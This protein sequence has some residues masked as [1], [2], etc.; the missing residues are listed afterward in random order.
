MK[1]KVDISM[2]AAAAGASLW[3]GLISSEYP[4]LG[5]AAAILLLLPCIA[6]LWARTPWAVVPLSWATAALVGAVLGTRAEAQE[7]RTATANPP[8]PSALASAAE[9][10]PRERVPA[11]PPVRLPTQAERA[12]AA[13]AILADRREDPSARYCN[14]RRLL[15]QVPPV[16]LRAREQRALARTYVAAERAALR[17]QRTEARRYAGLVCRDGSMSP[18]CMCAGSHRGCC[19]WHGGVAGCEPPPRDVLCPSGP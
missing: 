5:A 6:G 19:S 3:V 11:R 14:A 18:T 8:P 13:A 9:P 15:E 7:V 2:I 4:T 16:D 17:V 10:T 12:A 1:M